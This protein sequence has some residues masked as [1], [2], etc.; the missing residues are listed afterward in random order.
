MAL[1]Y[2]AFRFSFR[3]ARAVEIV[4]VARDKLT[5]RRVDARGRAAELAL[6]PYW[7]RLEVERHP[8]FGILG[9][10]IASHG[11]RFHVGRFLPPPE[12]ERF[13][14]ALKDALAAVR[15]APAA[16]SAQESGG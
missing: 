12:R 13:A 6:N 10:A 15:A 2:L 14:A 9:M 3:A 8:E 5:V 4:T 7:V 11:R 16:W 1:V